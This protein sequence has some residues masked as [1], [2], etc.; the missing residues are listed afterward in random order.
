MTVSTQPFL[1]LGT[2]ILAVSQEKQ[3]FFVGFLVD[4]GGELSFN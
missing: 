3:I 2:K 1:A 4:V